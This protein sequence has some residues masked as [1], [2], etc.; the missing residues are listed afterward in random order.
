MYDNN[1]DV[2]NLYFISQC[3]PIALIFLAQMHVYIHCGTL[4]TRSSRKCWSRMFSITIP[5]RFL[6]LVGG[7]SRHTHTHAHTHTINKYT[8]IYI[9]ILGQW[10]QNLV[11]MLVRHTTQHCPVH[12]QIYVSLRY[13]VEMVNLT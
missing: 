9:Y 7:P 12:E 2:L 10:F 6:R 4:S 1:L 11:W 13:F 3:T 8:S 5:H